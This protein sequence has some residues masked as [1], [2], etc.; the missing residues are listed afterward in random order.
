MFP[1]W[2]KIYWVSPLHGGV[3]YSTMFFPYKSI[4]LLS[5]GMLCLE[6]A[7]MWRMEWSL[8]SA[9]A[10]GVVHLGMAVPSLKPLSLQSPHC[11]QRWEHSQEKCCSLCY[12]NSTVT[13]Q[14]KCFKVSS[15]RENLWLQS[16][17]QRQCSF[18]GKTQH[19][20]LLPSFLWCGA[21]QAFF[22][23]FHKILSFYV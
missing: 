7:V 3:K 19:V 18:G 2:W 5:S 12:T 16:A 8:G 14:M 13:S 11:L 1:Q 23:I 6:H 15:H 10:P 17:V 4:T 21:G 9:F 22:A 20:S